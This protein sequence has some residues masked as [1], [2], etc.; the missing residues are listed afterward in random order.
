MPSITIQIPNV[1][2]EAY[3]VFK[4]PIH[5]YIKNTYNLDSLAIKLKVIS[6]ISMK[7]MIRNDLRD[8]YTNIY[9]PAT[10]S[11]VEYKKDLI[12]NVPI[13]SFSFRDDNGVERFI[14][15]PLN[16]ILSVS[17]I[18]S[19]EYINKLIVIDLNKLPISMDIT[20]HFTDL[21]SFIDSRFGVLPE[22]KEVALGTVELVTQTEH[23]T[24]ETIR[25]N[26]LTVFKTTEIQLQE[27]NVKYNNLIDRLTT[28]GISLG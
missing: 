18:T 28:L 11:E 2:I 20:A 3:F 4:D 22:I 5:T 25:T 21:S 12:D 6:V 26:S 15:S 23:N 13:V 10:I 1:G 16:Y 7:D 9:L 8:P 17:S 27:L 24:R 14:R 19:I